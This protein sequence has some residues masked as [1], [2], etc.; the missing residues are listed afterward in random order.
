MEGLSVRLQFDKYDG[1]QPGS[2]NDS[3]KTCTACG[4]AKPLGD[5]CSN[6][7]G[8]RHSWCDECRKTK[9][10]ERYA[11]SKASKSVKPVVI[12][13]TAHARPVVPV[14][15]LTATKTPVLPAKK[16][17][18]PGECDN[19]Q[20]WDQA[21]GQTLSSEDRLEIKSNLKRFFTIL[22]DQHKTQ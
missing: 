12:P 9:S 14:L 3:N 20:M 6:G 22:L 10:A 13:P 18:P 1:E 15:P 4:Y 19:F 11:R 5:F 16:S 7:S 17:E 8:R 2:H 21:Y